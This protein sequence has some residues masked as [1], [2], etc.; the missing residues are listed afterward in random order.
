MGQPKPID[1]GPT[2]D[3]CGRPMWWARTRNG[4]PIPVDPEPEL[5]L[6]AFPYFE[7]AGRRRDPAD[8]KELRARIEEEG[9]AVAVQSLPTFTP[10]HA[11]C[12]KAEDF[13]GPR[14]NS[15]P[16]PQIER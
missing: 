3:G 13:R 4:T 10:H 2:C 16:G 12:P 14:R 15:V 6:V 7:G 5:R 9:K 8:L 1:A 11:T